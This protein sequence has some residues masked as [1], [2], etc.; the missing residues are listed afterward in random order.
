MAN[1]LGSQRNKKEVEKTYNG[2]QNL[3]YLTIRVSKKIL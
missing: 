2:F 3:G 1:A